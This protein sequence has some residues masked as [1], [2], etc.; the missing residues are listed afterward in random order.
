ME[1]HRRRRSRPAL[2]RGNRRRAAGATRRTPTPEGAFPAPVVVEVAY[3]PAAHGWLGA[4]ASTVATIRNSARHRVVR[5]L[6][7]EI[8]AILGCP[9]APAP[10]AIGSK[11][12]VLLP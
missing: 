8:A 4:P 1:E 9:A 7:E 2:P 11:S 10:R 5:R 3:G 6:L 12:A